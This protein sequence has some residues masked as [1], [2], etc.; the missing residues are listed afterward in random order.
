VKPLQYRAGRLRTADGRRDAPWP[1]LALLGDPVAHS[2]SP[3]LF[4]AALASRGHD[5]SYAA[6]QVVA[7]N[8]AECLA[9]AHAAGLL[10]LNVTVPH[11]LAALTLAVGC[12]ASAQVVGAANTLARAQGG[13]R[14]HNTDAAGLAMALRRTPWAAVAPTRTQPAVVVGAGGAARAAVAALQELNAHSIAVLAR[15]PDAAGWAAQRGARVGPLDDP[16]LRDAALVIQATPLGLRVDDPSPVDV[17]QLRAGALVVDLT[18]SVV[19]SQLL[20]AASRRGCPVMDGIPMLIAQAALAFSLW[21]GG[22]PP[23][24]AM[25]ASLGRSW[26]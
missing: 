25:A 24:Q 14:A 12:D 22:E 6:V 18:Y 8:L 26:D 3:R 4:A 21:L 13:W 23:L 20:R 9:H 10:G 2:L 19:P 15:R 17:A 1:K 16:V 5:A 7:A 11:K